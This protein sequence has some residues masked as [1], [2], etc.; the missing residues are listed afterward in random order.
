[1]AEKV[2]EAG[3][4]LKVWAWVFIVLSL[5]MP[6]FGIGSIICSVKYKKYQQEQGG[7]LLNIA[8]IVTVVSVAFAIMRLFN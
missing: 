7:K 2:K 6:I 5:I 8:I 4:T 1:M 3:K